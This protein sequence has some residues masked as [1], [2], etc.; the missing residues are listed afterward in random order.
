LENAAR[1]DNYSRKGPKV[2]AGE[3]ACHVQPEKKN[4]FYAALCEASFLTGIE[5]NAD[6]VKLATYAPLFAHVD[7]WQWKPDMI[8][9]DNLRSVKSANYYVQQLYSKYKGTSVQKVTMNG[10]N[11]TGQEGIYASVV[12]DENKNQL[13]VKISNTG[14]TEKT[15]EF[16][17]KLKGLPDNLKGKQITLK[18][19]LEDE[20]TLDD[21]F[22]VKP[23][24][25]EISLSSKLPKIQIEP[26]SFHVF[27]LD[28]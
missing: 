14:K 6:V 2:F 13:I 18:A 22:L 1:Y 21:P 7:A 23:V 12:T 28:L 26:E 24:E 15:V 8:W 19:N 10:E 4:S 11:V 3:Y 16:D 9:F 25:K 5:R 27:V 20:N 17:L